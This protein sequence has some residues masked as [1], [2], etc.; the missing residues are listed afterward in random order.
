M[1]HYIPLKLGICAKLG[2]C[3]ANLEF[4]V[5]WVNLGLCKSILSLIAL[6]C[7]KMITEH[8]Y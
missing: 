2:L 3:N 4:H 8:D 7:A 1:L 5:W 6:A